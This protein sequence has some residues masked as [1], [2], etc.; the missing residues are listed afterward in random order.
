M[1]TKPTINIVWFKRDLRLLDHEPLHKA[2]TNGLPTLL[3]YTFEPSLLNDPHYS[4]RHW[5]FIKES[6]SDMNS[7]LNEFNTQL[8]A[9]TNEFIPTLSKLQQFWTIKHLYSHQETGLRVTYERDK[10]VKRFCKNNLIRWEE[11]ITNGVERGLQN[12]NNWSDKWTAYML[13]PKY[14]FD[15]S[16][17]NFISKKTLTTISTYFKIPCLKTPEKSLFQ[18]GGTNMGIKYLHSFFNDGRYKN[19][20]SHISKPTL[21]RKSCSRL[22]PYL[23]W[24]NLSIRQVWQHAKVFRIEASNKRCIDGFTSRLRWQAHFIQKFEMEDRM[25]FESINRGYHKLK[26][27]ISELYHQAWVSGTTGYPIVDACIRCLNTTGYLNFR[28]RALVVSFYT[29]NLWQPWQG[30]TTHLSQQFLDFEPGIHFPQ[31]QMQ[32]GETG[33]NML[34]IYNPI[35]NSKAHDPDGVFI[36]K[37]VPELKDIPVQYIHEPYLIPPLEQ[38]FLNFE[39]GTD[40]PLPIIELH[41]T[42]QKASDT[43]WE[44]KDDPTVKS[45]S[46]RILNKHTLSDRNNFD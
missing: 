26:K 36:K 46:F 34:R 8:L 45:E 25:E 41:K 27:N 38:Q 10:S 15:P 5:N 31:L 11:S 3:L 39:I 35:K 23:A 29:H 4:E 9:I 7:E 12:R 13:Q 2:I 44:L 19:Y 21:A 32:A 37:W 43:L 40:Y 33:I 28:M 14:D 1:T 20:N 42:R 18:K 17:S 16:P 24:G 6:I 22:S 30:A